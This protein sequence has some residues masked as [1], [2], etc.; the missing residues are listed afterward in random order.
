MATRS[1]AATEKIPAGPPDLEALLATPRAKRGPRP[2]WSHEVQMVRERE[3]NRRTSQ[4]H[5]WAAIA[6]KQLHR[7]EYEALLKQA[8]AKVRA[9][10]GPLPGDE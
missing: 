1:R 2:R 6:L 4:A 7:D 8:S 9:E 10:S 3:L 5:S